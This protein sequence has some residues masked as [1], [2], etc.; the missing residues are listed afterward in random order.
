M[1]KGT[2]ENSSPEK[3]D[4]KITRKEA[5]R[6]AGYAAFSATTMM[7]LLNNPTKVHA[8]SNDTTDSAAPAPSFEDDG[9]EW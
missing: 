2:K 5:I 8:S 3:G 9:F 4:R 6:K 1:G 7:L